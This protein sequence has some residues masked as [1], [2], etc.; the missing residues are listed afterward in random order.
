M[1]SSFSTRLKYLRLKV[2]SLE[3]L[4]LYISLHS[5]S[6]LLFHQITHILVSE[7][8]RMFLLHLIY[9]NIIATLYAN[10]TT[11]LELLR[12]SLQNGS[13]RVFNYLL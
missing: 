9:P 7:N 6:L 4:I 2:I 13:L 3:H 10:F 5:V 11:N 12:H 1:V 8:G